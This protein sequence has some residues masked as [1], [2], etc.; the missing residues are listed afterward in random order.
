MQ[1]TAV[2]DAF[3]FTRYKVNHSYW[4]S[5]LQQDEDQLAEIRLSRSQHF[6]LREHTL[7]LKYKG[8][9][10]GIPLNKIAQVEL[11]FKRLILPIIT[12]GIVGPLSVISIYSGVMDPWISAGLLLVGGMLAY[13]G[14]TGA[15]QFQITFVNGLHFS[16]FVDEDSP[17]I[18]QFVNQVAE[19]LYQIRQP[20]PAKFA[21]K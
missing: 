2:P 4:Y 18:K 17:A 6:I 7:Y 11:S 14:F 13:Y 16:V 10:H 21:E 3:E 9:E 15:F 5:W 8:R 12:G 19:R 1:Q 20:K